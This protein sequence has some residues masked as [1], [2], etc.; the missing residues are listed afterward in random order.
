[1]GKP[2]SPPRLLSLGY[3]KHGLVQNLFLQVGKLK[4]EN[5]R[6]LVSYQVAS[7]YS[8]E[9]VQ[10]LGEPQPQPNPWPTPSIRGPS[11]QASPSPSQCAGCS[12]FS[13]IPTF[14]LRSPPI[15]PKPD[16]PEYVRTNS[17][18]SAGVHHPHPTPTPQPRPMCVW[19]RQRQSLRERDLVPGPPPQ[20]V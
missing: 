11:L 15:L 16:S 5:S 6:W 1:M 14:S 10:V 4:P 12:A 2:T 19:E 7:Q 9:W 8:W 18:L 17:P 13:V 3:A 20:V